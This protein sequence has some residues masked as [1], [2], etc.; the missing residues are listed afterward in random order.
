MLTDRNTVPRRGLVLEMVEAMFTGNGRRPNDRAR[1]VRGAARLMERVSEGVTVCMV[2][3][4]VVDEPAHSSD[5][6]KEN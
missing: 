1:A 4:A 5:D 3:E 6:E 2:E